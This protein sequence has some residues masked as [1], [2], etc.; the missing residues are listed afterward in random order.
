MRSSLLLLSLISLTLDGGLPDKIPS[1][2]G[3]HPAS[4]DDFRVADNDCTEGKKVDI[5]QAFWDAAKALNMDGVKANINWKSPATVEFLG[6][7]RN[8]PSQGQIQG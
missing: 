5:I 8:K 1:V 3:V 2:D 6:A 4:D 7:P